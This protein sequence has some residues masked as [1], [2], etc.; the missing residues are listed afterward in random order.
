MR[1]P[2]ETP[3]EARQREYR[4]NTRNT[5]AD[6]LVPYE[7]NQLR[8]AINELSSNLD[9]RTALVE[10]ALREGLTAIALAASTPEDNSAE[11]KAAIE[12]L[13]QAKTSLKEA[14]EKNQPSKE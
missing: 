3:E 4:E 10:G 6:R 5:S 13:H 12:K 1:R 7:I 8:L 9:K 14:V 2:Q 11:V